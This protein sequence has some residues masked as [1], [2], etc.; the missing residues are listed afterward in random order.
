MGRDDDESQDAPKRILLVDDDPMVSSTVSRALARAG[1]IVTPC[2]DPAAGVRAFAEQRFDALVTDF[3]M[4]QMTGVELAETLR[5]RA[6]DLPVLF[7]SGWKVEGERLR[8]LGNARA[9]Q[10]PF[11]ARELVDEVHALFSDAPGDPVDDD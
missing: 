5:E 1:W 2:P 10:K 7:L 8:S 6:P 4:P 11:R 9:M 3:A